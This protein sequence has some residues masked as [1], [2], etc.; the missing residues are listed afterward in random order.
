MR[1]SIGNP[2]RISDS[3]S[4]FAR[5]TGPCTPPLAVAMTMG[6]GL[7]VLAHYV[8][9]VTLRRLCALCS[10]R[11]VTACERKKTS[12]ASRWLVIVVAI[13]VLV[14]DASS[15]PQAHYELTA[16]LPLRNGSTHG[17]TRI[18]VRRGIVG[19]V[20]RLA[21]SDPAWTADGTRLA[22]I[23][24]SRL[25]V[26]G[27]NGQNTKAV[28]GAAR[29]ATDPDWSPDGRNIVFVCGEDIFGP[30]RA[31]GICQ[32]E[33]D[34]RNLRLLV[35]DSADPYSK[36][37]FYNDSPRWSPAGGEIAFVRVEIGS[38]DR[39]FIEVV[40]LDGSP[41]RRLTSSDKAH[42]P[43]WHP[44]GSRLA[45][46]RRER[47]TCAIEVISRS[48]VVMRQI[49]SETHDS[50]RDI[51]GACPHEL[52]WSPDGRAIAFARGNAGPSI[53]LVQ[54]AAPTRVQTIASNLPSP[55]I[56]LAWRHV[57]G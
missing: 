16:G 1:L 53:S 30:P 26:S 50:L 55:L 21:G 22:F 14:A 5:T 10:R 47:T 52:A 39:E 44:S 24:K 15:G 41:P 7:A 37:G 17:I 11:P 19:T 3:L 48:G 29:P 27:A 25:W 23:R 32:V 57:S 2:T 35:R 18:D 54:V 45:Y 49:L 56:G 42:S 31:T 43:T 34:G 13:G 12:V 4:R 9:L 51:E 20:G 40:R 46:R 8:R 36:G 38:P 33:A 6:P 28:T